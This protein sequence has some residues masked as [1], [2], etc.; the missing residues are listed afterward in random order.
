MADKKD[1]GGKVRRWTEERF[2]LRQL[3]G[4]LLNIFPV[5]Y[6]ELDQRLDIK[7]GLQKLLKKPVPKHVS[8]WHCFGG[9][10]FLLFVIQ[11]VTGIMLATYYKPSAADAYVRKYR[12]GEDGGRRRLP[13]L[14]DGI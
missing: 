2:N 10:T 9:I 11:V 6:G 7:E 3:T 1:L 14:L 5:I 13:E 12:A 4:A 8:F